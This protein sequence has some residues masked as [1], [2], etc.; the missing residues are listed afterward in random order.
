MKFTIHCITD[1]PGS[2]RAT[3][4]QYGSPLIGLRIPPDLLDRLD[5]AREDLN[6]QE[7]IRLLMDRF[8]PE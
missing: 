5:R 6:R 7:A 2:M 8:L 3:K 4:P 1:E